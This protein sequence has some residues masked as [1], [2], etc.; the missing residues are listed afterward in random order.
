MNENNQ[1][2]VLLDNEEF[3]PYSLNTIR[4]VQLMPE[5]LVKLQSEDEYRPAVYYPELRDFLMHNDNLEPS[6]S[7]IDLYSLYFYYRENYQKYG[8]LSLWELSLLDIDEDTQLSI[9]NMQ[10]W[11]SAKSIEG[12]ITTINQISPEVEYDKFKLDKE[13]L[14]DIIKDQE[15]DLANKEKELE[16]KSKILSEQQKELLEK[17]EVI[18]RFRR[19]EQDREIKL[20]KKQKELE[21]MLSELKT[22]EEPLIEHLLFDL[23]SDYKHK[24]LSCDSQ[25]KNLIST[26]RNFLPK[27]ENFVKV[28]PNRDAEVEYN[29]NLYREII[30]DFTKKLKQIEEIVNGASKAYD[31]DIQLLENSLSKLQQISTNQK[32]KEAVQDY[33]KKIIEIEGLSLTSK[34][35]ILDSLKQGLDNKK[36]E[37]L[38]QLNE[39]KRKE[40][41]RI[42]EVKSEISK[43]YQ[44]ILNNSY[45][46]EEVLQ[47]IH[48][49]FSKLFDK[50]YDTALPLSDIWKKIEDW[51]QQPPTHLLLGSKKVSTYIG[52]KEVEFKKR[53][54]FGFLN[55]KH[56][57]LRYNKS[58]KSTAEAFVTTL[59][60]RLVAS[61]CP[62]D[63]QVSMLDIED[64]CGTS[65][66]LTKLNRQVYSLCVK[67][68]DVRRIIDWMK[69]HI[70]DVKVNLLL[71]PINSLKEYN[72]KKDNKEAYQ[73][74]VIKGFPFGFG[75]EL[76]SVFN[77]LLRNGINAGVNIVMLVDEDE[78]ETNDDAKKLMSRISNDAFQNCSCVNFVTNQIGCDE[79]CELD[80]LSDE[81]LT[82]IIYN[83]NKRFEVK[84]DDKAI[85]LSDYL[86]AEEDWWNLHS[87][88]SVEIP[89]G[90]ADDKQVAKLKIT[91][92][93]GQNSAV[94]IGIPGS[95][96]SVFLHSIICNA[97]VNYSP[98]E[99]NLYLIDFSGV[100]F[101]TYANHQLPHARVIAPEAEREFGL[102]ILT[103]LVEEG[104]R[105]MT[106]CRENEVSNIVDLK[107]RHPGI[108]VP[109]LL[110]IID[111]FQKI[112][113]IENDAISRE[114]N[115]KIHIIIQEFRKF[116]INL[117]L[118]TQR[119]PSGSILPK[120]LIANRVVFKSSANDFAALITLPSTL[121][122]P[123]LRT[124][125]CIYNSESG[126][127]YDNTRVQGFFIS[128]NDINSLLDNVFAHSKHR[129][130]GNSNMIVFRGNDLPSFCE[131]RIEKGHCFTTTIPTEVGIYLGES[132][133]INDTDVCAVIR[134]ETGN[135]IIV[136]GG[137]Q[138]VA[139]RIAYYATL[140]T[141]TA[142]SDNS[143]IFYVF[144]HLR[145]EEDIPELN[146]TFMSLPFVV[147]MANKTD[148]VIESLTE[149][150]AEIEARKNDET[151][152]M[153]HI[154]L[155]FYGF[156]LA[157]MYDRGGRRGDDVSECGKLL[158]YILR[159]GS[160][161]GIFAILQVDNLDNFSRIGVP[162]SVFNYRIALQMSENDSNKVVAS[163]IANKLFV[164]NRPSSIY[165]AYFRD[166]NRNLT[167]KFKPYK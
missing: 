79:F 42:F 62:G 117:I 156:Q 115:S 44:Q 132:I 135:N 145:P 167:V 29:L 75:G 17:N 121:R 134:K 60:G 101:N 52:N 147:K 51:K 136:I 154:Y 33:E 112:F 166:N 21:Q 144:N 82:Q 59:I 98:E 71:S 47:S 37:I 91:Q 97:I 85:L 40:S 8:P 69:D 76:L 57:L 25:L 66:I 16:S 58:T 133:A 138:K 150:Q 67:S 160:T 41:L 163:S 107:V 89:F 109:R 120:D 45:Q 13:E 142:H 126:S 19:E 161:Y 7:N 1:Y 23:D 72:E 39:E 149:I 55:S 22:T 162:I 38:N 105:R 153:E 110:V 88:R 56:L 130:V 102:S 80:I 5:T 128:M 11:V 2:V 111:E 48:N 73:V 83:V 32:V 116:G 123:Q 84:E 119:L 157:R 104:N 131:R 34:E 46:V 99:L 63:V 26:L 103:E 68:D 64:M 14:K 9:D 6:I 36:I 92:E 151:R 140:S 113:E 125:E 12:L 114:A 24:Y 100:E 106:L 70:A 28:F 146:D 158:D 129:G 65:N 35:G 122:V 137:E 139:Q 3:G 108:K 118:A 27:E 95:G 77:S 87:A 143:A 141:T 53:I 148:D 20:Q 15:E 49:K 78:T 81:V 31:E 165:R 124:G 93:S 30:D 10:S 152:S 74:L 155:S 61:S 159:N 96:K 94:V 4:E 43:Q 90:L 86:S 18:E 127:Q 54:F 164:F 50:S